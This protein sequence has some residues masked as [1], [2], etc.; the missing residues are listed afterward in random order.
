[1]SNFLGIFIFD[2]SKRCQTK[3]RVYTDLYSTNQSPNYP[4]TTPTATTA[5]ATATTATN[6][7][8]TKCGKAEAT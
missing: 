3:G 4:T 2:V 1:M 8:T 7:A 5:I 6:T